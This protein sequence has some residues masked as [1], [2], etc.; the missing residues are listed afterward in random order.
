MGFDLQLSGFQ[1]AGMLASSSHN[2]KTRAQAE[3]A[4]G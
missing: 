1:L 2:A 4:R 3:R